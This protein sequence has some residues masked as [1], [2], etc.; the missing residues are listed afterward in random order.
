MELTDK[1][2]VDA[3]VELDLTANAKLYPGVLRPRGTVVIY[4]TGGGGD[5]TGAM[6]PGE[7]H[8]AEVRLRLRAHAEERHAAIDTI[9]RMLTEK[10][11]ATMWPRP[12]PSSDIVV[13]HET[14]EQGKVAGNVVVRISRRRG[15]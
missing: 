11:L 5:A 15:S 4:G 3:I 14:V 7:R 1:A 13:A 6:A 9:T 2:G 10:R 12:C 8:R